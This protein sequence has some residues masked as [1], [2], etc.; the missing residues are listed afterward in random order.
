MPSFFRLTTAAS[1]SAFEQTQD[2][3]TFDGAAETVPSTADA[4]IVEGQLSTAR[5]RILSTLVSRAFQDKR[6]EQLPIPD[7]RFFTFFVNL[8]VNF[9]PA[10]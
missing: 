6:V 10:Y 2:P 5:L 9:I 1:G 7:V 8:C 4:T 3:Y